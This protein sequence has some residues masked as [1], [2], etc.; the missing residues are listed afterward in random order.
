MMRLP[1]IQLWLVLLVEVVGAGGLAADPPAAAGPGAASPKPGTVASLPTTPGF[2]HL[3]YSFN[4]LIG[5][6]GQYGVRPRTMSYDI[7]LPKGYDPSHRWPMVVYLVGQGDRGEDDSGLYH[8]GP[9]LYLKTDKALADWAPFIELTPRCPADVGWDTPG[10]TESVIQLITQVKSSWAVDPDRVYLTGL[11]MGGVGTWR[12]ALQANHMFA[13][14]APMCALAVEP[15]HMA[16][17]VKGTTVC[18]I[19]GALDDVRT[20]QSRQMF[21]ALRQAQV[22]VLYVEVPGQGHA[23][24]P[25]FYASRQFYEFLLMNRRG[26]KPPEH[27]LT[28]EQLVAIGNTRPDSADADLAQPLQKFLPWWFLSN[29]G[30]ADAP[31]LKDQM[32]GRKN[33]FVT[34]PL[35]H[36]VPCCLM[37]TFAVAKQK[38]TVLKLT[39]GAPPQGQW[40]LVV[41]AESK[42]LLRRTI[43]GAPAA[44][45][46]AAAGPW[47]DLDVDLSAFAGQKVHL[48]LQDRYAGAAHAAAYWGK[49]QI[50]EE[51]ISGTK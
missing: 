13:A 29:C 17:A 25:P 46:G 45:A 34:T 41:R 26:E 18:I 16:A 8:T 47:V 10:M 35:D 31:G 27:R 14:I 43:T 49:V 5:Y 33:V 2:H 44:G 39:L 3:S 23:V 37:Y 21:N 51:A 38:K 20:T 32:L 12:A 7:W 11:S 28:T 30:H 24:W 50:V 48:E 9:P 22:D 15:E 6:P 19:C 1:W 4:G 42:D 36:D 40:E